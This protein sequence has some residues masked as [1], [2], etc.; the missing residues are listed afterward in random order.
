V[1]LTDRAC[2]IF[3]FRLMPEHLMNNWSRILTHARQEHPF[4]AL[5]TLSMELLGLVANVNEATGAGGPIRR[6]RQF[7]VRG[8]TTVAAAGG[9]FNPSQS[10]HTAS[11]HQTVSESASKLMKTYGHLN[12]DSKISEIIIDVRQLDDSSLAHKAAKRAITRITAR[13]YVFTDTSGVSIRQLLALVYIA[14]HD[15]TKRIGTLK[16]A[17][18]LFIHALYEIQRGYNINSLGQDDNMIADRAICMAGTFNK[19]I[20]KLH[21]LHPDAELQYVSTSSAAAKLP[22]IVRNHALKFLNALASSPETKVKCLELVEKIQED[23]YLEPTFRTL[24]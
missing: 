20:E 17:K 19:L 12:L 3:W 15:D 24:V 1:L 13:D 9:N 7:V 14:I 21:G 2:Q 16:D 18:K 5:E 8:T 11:V 10:T 23:G 6:G 4:A 22:I